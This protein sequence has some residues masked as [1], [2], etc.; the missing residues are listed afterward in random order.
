MD[1][2]RI[3]NYCLSLPAVTEDMPFG[4]GV[5]VFRLENKIFACIAFDDPFAVTLKCDPEYALELREAH[6]EIDG[7]FHWNKRHWNSIRFDG[8]LSDRFIEAL[9]RHAYSR[10]VAKLPAKVKVVNPGYLEVV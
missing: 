10:I 6:S 4:E 3:R 7:A 2:E 5:V 1:I 8:K 9:V